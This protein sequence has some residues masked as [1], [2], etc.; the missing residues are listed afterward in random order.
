[1]VMHSPACAGDRLLRQ[2]KGGGPRR[3][4][5]DPERLESHLVHVCRAGAAD[6]DRGYLF[7]FA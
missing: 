2:I 5:L 6:G 1:M 3:K 7:A 4:K